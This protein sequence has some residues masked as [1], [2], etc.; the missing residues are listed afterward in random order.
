[1]RQAFAQAV[2][3]PPGERLA[4]PTS[5]CHQPASLALPHC[6]AVPRDPEL[7]FARTSARD[8]LSAGAN[9]KIKAVINV[10]ASANS[11]HCAG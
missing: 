7:M 5:I 3:R 9:P 11:C 1:M 2:R 10:A 4:R 6:A 8:A